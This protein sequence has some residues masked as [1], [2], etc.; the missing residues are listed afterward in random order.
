MDVLVLG[1]GPA[2]LQLARFL[3]GY[4]DGDVYVYE[5]HERVG[6]PQHCTGLVSIEGLRKWIGVGERGLVLNRFRGARFVSPSG[7]VFLARRGSEVAA[8]IE[9]KLLEEKLY[10]EAVSAGARVLLG[11]RQTLGGFALSVRKRGA[12]GVIAGGTGFLSVLHG[13]KREFLLPALQLDVRV[14]DEV[15]DTD[16]LYVFLGE[17]FSRGLFAWAIPLE[18]GT[19]RVGL[20]SRGNVLLRLKYL[21]LALSRVGV[22]VVKRLRV[23]GGAVYTGG[24]V[25]VYAGD[26]LFLLGDS[27][28]QTK[29]T[30]GGGLVYLSIAA[31]ALSDA[32]LSDRP[33]AYGEAVKRAL[34]REMHVQLLVRKALNS[35]SD[36]ELDELFQAL[37]EVGGEEIVA[38]E[39]SMDVQSAVALKLSAKLFLSR[40]TLLASAAL[41]SLAF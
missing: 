34:G 31:R 37:K 3:K 9:R 12:I 40:P 38:S 4:G 8:I 17:K 5:E 29:P 25:D 36:A 13:E 41:K 28:G 30:T 24:M 23:F 20:A 19:Y 32:I 22:K 2:G 27:A 16:H 26:R 14:E 6:L 11:A 10:E 21:M 18:D 7:K 15:G 35:L 39:G 33:E 1:G